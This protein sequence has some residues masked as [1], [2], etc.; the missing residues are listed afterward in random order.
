MPPSFTR[1]AV[2]VM[3]ERGIYPHWVEKVVEAPERLEPDVQDP[4]RSL[5]FGRMAEFG[6][7]WLRVVYVETNGQVRIITAFFDRGMERRS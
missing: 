6:N 1:R 7:R 4:A 3:N 2:E 5:A